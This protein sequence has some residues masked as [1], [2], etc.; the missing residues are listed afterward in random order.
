MNP[1]SRRRGEPLLVLG[2][3]LLS[4]VG[5]RAMLW[6]EPYMPVVP[7]LTALRPQASV[8]ARFVSHRSPQFSQSAA[9]T[10]LGPVPALR[11]WRPEPLALRPEDVTA[12]A[13]PAQP[14]SRQGVAAANQLLWMA[15]MAGLPSPQA[16]LGTGSGM[17]VPDLARVRAGAERRWSGD[18]WLMWRKGDAHLGNG[19]A[20]S[21]YG[22]SQGGLVLRY[23]L[24]PSSPLQPTLYMRVTGAMDGSGQADSAFGFSARPIAGLP[25]IAAVEGR[26]TRLGNGAARVRPAAMVVTEL[27]PQPMP[28]AMRAE[29]Y[30]AAGYVGGP[31]ATAFV[32]GQLRVDH[33]V[34][35]FGP[36][37]IRAGGG[38]W[39]G[40][41]AGV[42]RLDVGPTATVRV[43]GDHF[44]ARL[45]VDWRIRVAGDAAPRS[46]PAMTLAAG[47]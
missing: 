27:T 30:A 20:P 26:V 24:V 45:G 29:M 34:A 47:F 32:D 1:R 12:S 11:P 2:V 28:F 38:V 17:V 16:L 37:E 10:A 22:A 23:R 25:L 31:G 18:G 39:G 43:A 21:T 3:L 14:V 35:S 44:A 5:L 8:R 4:W 13:N 19:P 33:H 40:A 42:G 9:P 6:Q 7:G 46:G 15:A 41:Q 36:S